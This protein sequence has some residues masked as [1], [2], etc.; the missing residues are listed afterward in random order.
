MARDAETERAGA[1][2]GVYRV[3]ALDGLLGIRRELPN[4]VPPLPSD[5]PVLP[6]LSGSVEGAAFGLQEG[7]LGPSDI[8]SVLASWGIAASAEDAPPA[9]EPDGGPSDAAEKRY[10]WVRGWFPAPEPG[11]CYVVEF[12]GK[13]AAKPLAYVDRYGRAFSTDE[14]LDIPPAREP[15]LCASR[16]ADQPDS[17]AVCGSVEVRDDDGSWRET[18]RFRSSGGLYTLSDS[19]FDFGS[20]GNG[21]S[22]RDFM[23]RCYLAFVHRPSLGAP[24]VPPRGFDG[25]ESALSS[26]PAAKALRR[27]SYAIASAQRDP[28]LH[29]PALARCL[30]RWLAEAGVDG[31]LAVSDDALRL[32]RTAR[33][34][35][36]FYVGVGESGDDLPLRQVWALQNALNRYLLAKE[37]LGEGAS[38]ASAADVLQEDAR[39]VEGVAAGALSA[40]PASSENEAQGEWGL[41]RALSLAAELLR[42]PLR[43][44]LDF[45]ADVE[46]GVVAFKAMVPDAALMPRQRWDDAAAAPVETTAAERAAQAVR[47]AEHLGLLFAAEAF[48][49][50]PRIQRVEF[51][52]YPPAEERAITLGDVLA[53]EGEQGAKGAAA[54]LSEL[55]PKPH[56]F[57]A[58]A[59]GRFLE[60]FAAALDDDPRPFFEAMGAQVAP[61]AL[62]EV[63]AGP[64]AAALAEERGVDADSYRGLA[65]LPSARRRRDA[66]EFAGGPIP[67]PLRAAL[68][69]RDLHDLRIDAT[70]FDQREAERLANRLAPTAS[71]SA[72][73]D[74][75][76]RLQRR[77]DNP[78]TAQ[79]CTRLMTALAE[80]TADPQDQNT[81]VRSYLGEDPCR[82]ALRRAQE[83]AAQG[84]P[85]PAARLL[86]DAARKAEEGGRFADD[87]EVVHRFFDAYP[88]RLR[89]NLARSG[90]LPASGAV[91]PDAPDAAGAATDAS[92]SADP[93]AAAGAAGFGE[94]DRGRRVELVPDSLMRCHLEAARLLEHSFAGMDDALA[95]ARRAVALAPSLAPPRCLLARVYML[96][97]DM[98]SAERLLKQAL[99]LA[100]RPDDI[101]VA[102]YQ[103]AYVLWKA[104]DARVGAACYLR[105]IGT[106][107]AMAV[108]AVSELRQLVEQERPSL[109]ST[110][111]VEAELQRAGVPD[112]PDPAFLDA[113]LPAAAAATEAGA[114]PV[115]RSLLAAYQHYRS[116]DV[117]M[118]V[119]R[120][121]ADLRA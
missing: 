9:A 81:V 51:A 69:A 96:L 70:A 13:R 90:A 105:S 100:V 47:Y 101:A 7:L 83:L 67:E 35:D 111:E 120:S 110:A 10:G 23:A 29:V 108:Q 30:E 37:S 22:Y 91:A 36:I 89:Y 63:E 64:F 46:A 75:V 73:M 3:S 45:R 99:A 78:F 60:G 94:A 85:L 11:G 34:A 27:T 2:E 84:Q 6:W 87:A 52:A 5:A 82:D 61:G 43:F 39:L 44:E 19:W 49:R 102:Y 12:V 31:L 107:P 114:F 26:L 74:V 77:T 57:V 20:N 98:A 88:A 17:Q 118:G 25:M 48:L 40:P 42:A 66:P 58:F 62:E 8:M 80:G 16:D 53:A 14:P 24:A 33:Y 112:A 119:L 103:L 28:A 97:G 104:G 50:C 106:S 121:L 54:D 1:D 18:A 65:S 21:L 68:G 92:P 59:R 117:L 109:L 41:R 15:D 113:L 32:V 95:H 86:S 55:L 79:A 116:D 72:A 93:G 76:R 115:A 38:T 4:A 56:L 71:I